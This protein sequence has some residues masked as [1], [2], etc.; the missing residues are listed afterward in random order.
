[1]PHRLV[2]IQRSTSSSITSTIKAFKSTALLS[3][4]RDAWGQLVRSLAW[5]LIDKSRLNSFGRRRR[6]Q[7]RRVHNQR[8][9]AD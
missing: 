1:M 5:E 7:Q 9:M 3:P 4:N 8:A 6:G 2:S